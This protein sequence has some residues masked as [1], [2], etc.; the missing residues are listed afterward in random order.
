M[1]LLIKFR[2]PSC[3]GGGGGGKVGSYKNDGGTAGSHQRVQISDG[4]QLG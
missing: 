4:W 2:A 1:I 3:L